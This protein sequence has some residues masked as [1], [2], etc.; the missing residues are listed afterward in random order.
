MPT[1][2]SQVYGLPTTARSEMRLNQQGML[3]WHFLNDSLGSKTKLSF[4]QK[5]NMIMFHY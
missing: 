3:V 1:L 4:S 5:W 2:S